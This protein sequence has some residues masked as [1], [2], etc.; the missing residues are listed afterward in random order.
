MARRTRSPRLLWI[1]DPW[2]TLDHPKDTTLRLMEESLRLGVPTSWT[3][4]RSLS[5]ERGATRGA[6]H[7]LK[8]IG[9]TR[10]QDSFQF[11]RLPLS[12]RISDFSQVHYRVDPPVD[13]SYI[14]PVH[15]L[16]LEQEAGKP[17]EL[18]NPSSALL[19]A[20][21][22]TES[23]LFEGLTV[24]SLV[25]A[26]PA[27]LL[28]FVRK[29]KRVVLKP[30]HQA[31]SKGI[32]LLELPGAGV[33]GAE[34]K[35][36]EILKQL[37]EATRQGQTPILLQRYLPGILEGETRLWFIDGRLLAT[38]R[39]RPSAGTFRIDMDRG[40]SLS[41]HRLSAREK[42]AVQTISKKLRGKSIR[43]AA[44]DLI[45]GKVT[46]TN[47]TSPGLLTPMETLLGENLAQS[48]IQSLIRRS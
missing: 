12:T 6:F 14:H 38:A 34:R 24:P 29:E 17:F 10:T 23:L 43:L 44:V 5:F 27:A 30:L 48:V 8:A 21:E 7:E 26:S 45:E 19:L 9:D 28:A 2:E 36:Q 15:L 18:V 35:T 42:R 37:Q 25:A 41:P 32:E 4:V 20:G 46:D 13:L 39:K 11:R 1:T 22:K 40:G 31:Q 16:N 3:D 47:F 33:A